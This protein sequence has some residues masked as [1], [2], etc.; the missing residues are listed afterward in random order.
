MKIKRVYVILGREEECLSAL[1]K[2]IKSI[3]LIVDASSTINERKCLLH[4]P[5]PRQNIIYP[6]RI[7]TRSNK[8]KHNLK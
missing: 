2:Y 1:F 3:N 5:C 8:F 6:T 4:F 7:I